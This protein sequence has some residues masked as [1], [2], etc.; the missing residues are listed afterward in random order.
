MSDLSVQQVGR[1]DHDTLVF[2]RAT[3]TDIA[4][5]PVLGGHATAA[6]PAG[7]ELGR[8]CRQPRFDF[9]L[10]TGVGQAFDLEPLQEAAEGTS[11]ASAALNKRR[12]CA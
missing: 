3:V 6:V 10:Q 8:P 12:P 9:G 7:R 1:L 5:D 11:R 4:A 2:R